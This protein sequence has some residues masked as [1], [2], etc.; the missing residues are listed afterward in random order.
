[1]SGST[2][3]QILGRTVRAQGRDAWRGGHG[4]GKQWE[5]RDGGGGGGW[6]VRG[7]GA[8]NGSALSWAWRW[9]LQCWAT[10]R[11]NH[12]VGEGK[13]RSRLKGSVGAQIGRWG[14][15]GVLGAPSKWGTSLVAVHSRVISG[16]SSPWADRRLLDGRALPGGC[17]SSSCQ[18]PVQGWGGGGGGGGK[19]DKQR[20]T[21]GTGSRRRDCL[22]S[23]H[24]MLTSLIRTS[25]PLARFQDV[26]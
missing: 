7:G 1:M 17:W 21:S 12:L 14:P 20:D 5:G 8:G 25:I 4:V 18:L 11:E 22:W 6:Q 2:S 23:F 24:H 13:Q 3:Q 16:G 19:A 15:G 26:L 9:C 10:G